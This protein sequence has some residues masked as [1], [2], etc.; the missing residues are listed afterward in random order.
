MM[1]FRCALQPRLSTIV[2]LGFAAVWSGAP[3]RIG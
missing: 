3:A 1:H 2:R